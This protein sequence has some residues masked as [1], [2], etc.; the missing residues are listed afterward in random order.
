MMKLKR[1]KR[2]ATPPRQR[3]TRPGLEPLESRVLFAFSA[4]VNF[5]PAGVPVPVGYVADTGLVYGA[6]NG[7][8]YGWNAANN[9][10]LDRNSSLSPDQR[11][12]TFN[13]LQATGAGNTWEIAVPNG[14]YQVT[15]VG[16]DSWIG[17]VYKIDVEGVRAIDGVQTDASRWL[18]GS[19]TIAVTDGKLTVKAGSGASGA[20][21]N[22]IQITEVPPPNPQP[23]ISG[24]SL[25][26]AATEQV[27]GTLTNGQEINQAVVGD[28]L[29]VLATIGGTTSGS[30]KFD[31]DGTYSRVESG[32]P[33][34]LFGDNPG[35][36]LPG[37][38]PVGTHQLVVTPYSAVNAGGIAGTP[39]TINFTVVNA[40]PPLFAAKINFQPAGT[41]IPAGYLADTGLVYG[42]RNGLTYGWNAANPNMVDRN[43]V[44]SPDQLRDTFARLQAANSGT[45]WEIA[46][47]NGNY[48]VTIVGG[49]AWIGG[50]Y[51][52]EVEGALAI[53]GVQTSASRWL[54]GNKT[55][56]VSDGKLTVKAAS[57][58]QGAK[59]NF[60][61]ITAV[62]TVPPGSVP[63][64]AGVTLVNAAT[65][66]DLGALF[67]GRAINLAELGT[68]LNLR[69]DLGA[70]PAG[71]VRFSID[72][73]S[74]RVDDGAIYTIGGDNGSDYLPWTP[75]VGNHRL[76]VTPYTGPGGTGTA[77][78][79]K[80]VDFKV[81][82]QPPPTVAAVTLV[83]AATDKDIFPLTEGQIL[84]LYTLGRQ[85]NI[86]ATLATSLTTASVKFV[87]D[88]V[89]RIESSAPF[90]AFSDDGG[91][92]VAWTPSPG[93]HTL[94][95]TPYS[96]TGAT[97]LAGPSVTVNFTVIDVAPPIV[98]ALMLVNTATGEPVL[99]LT[100]GMTLDLTQTGSALTV[101]ANVSPSTPAG[102][103]SFLLDGWKRTV[104][105]AGPF[106]AP[107]DDG[108]ATL[109]L[110][111]GFHTLTVIAA[112]AGDTPIAGPAYSVSFTVTPFA[113][114]VSP[115]TVVDQRLATLLNFSARQLNLT[116]DDFAGTGKFPQVTLPN[117]LWSQ[118]TAATWSSGFMPGMLWQMFNA[119]GDDYWREKAIPLANAFKGNV[120]WTEDTEFR[121]F[122]PML[123]LYAVT[124]DTAI[125]D[126]LLTAA[127][128]KS[129]QFD[130]DVQGF[131]TSWRTSSSGNPKANFGVLMD[132]MMDLELLFWAA[133][134]TGNQTYYNQ[135]VA[136]A[137]TVAKH[138]VRPDG[139]SFH[140]GYFDKDTGDFISGE[141]AQGYAN[142]ST[143]A[144]GQAWGM[145]AF[146]MAYRETGLTE[147][148]DTARKMS[149]WYIA[150]LPADKV[151]FW[152]FDDP[153]IPNTQKD[154][155][156][157]SLAA[158]ALLMISDLAS[159]PADKSTYAVAAGGMLE[160]LS[161][162]EYL[163]DNTQSRS[164]LNRGA[165]YVPAPIS[166]Q[167]SGLIWGDYYF[168]EALNRYS[169]RI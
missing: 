64:I 74:V 71:S 43:A 51:K 147:F 54:T 81:I 3:G 141:T 87:F 105:T 14:S 142:N 120:T 166:S 5:Q 58:A 155:S 129:A 119:T 59:V 23:V 169:G 125:R 26:N 93:P 82:N 22:F 16:G 67:N 18:S 164:I 66:S 8:T 61:D 80:T 85:L 78:T 163:A 53:D 134:Q 12:D 117:G 148:L 99:P 111:P 24:L 109:E 55:V 50:V 158:S 140:W 115:N 25:V 90:A 92:F 145:Y 121:C 132:Q 168:L 108:T 68:Q 42:V 162:P 48:Q 62:P 116:L 89:S 94:V 146:A 32:L 88:G 122:V 103:V 63:S 20:K 70:N 123:Q 76:V 152:D 19:K 28:Q 52:I 77:G 41:P 34:T 124:G 97:G 10:G 30:V 113:P 56:V 126:L 161:S 114:T 15:I 31:L 4:N 35:D 83:N 110:T 156:A 150:H 9:N 104:D 39:V 118:V 100:N 29:S 160:A 107:G 75:T 13:R 133:K 40:A 136:N 37:P 157:A 135:A 69:A 79:A 137:R 84:N 47:P 95:I 1:P 159:A 143:W 106:F 153:A 96:G 65:D 11:Y 112:T 144:R 127:A 7:L 167:E 138:L 17:G 60:I 139:S 128:N 49:D 27:I 149:D 6:R 165:W 21:V 151:P 36:I 46:V 38:L 44:E 101:R 72:G 45:I 33:Y 130:P 57:G 86:N 91:D 102:M 73:V 98:S 154:S 2:S 131:F